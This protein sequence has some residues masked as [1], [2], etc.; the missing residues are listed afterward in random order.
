MCRS[1]IKEDGGLVG[2]HLLLDAENRSVNLVVDVGQVGDSR[3]LSNTAELVV[4]GS[5]TEAN[6][7]LVGSEIGNGD[8]SQMGADS[9]AAQDGGVTGIRDLSLG[10]LVECGGGGERVGLVDLGL[11]ET[12]HKD[13]FS[14][15]G[16]LENLTWGELGDVQLLVGVSDVPVTGEHLVVDDSENGLDSENV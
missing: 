13:H 2:E 7:S 15:P 14:V 3:S 12:T 10:L 8:A 4:D 11:G 6:P 1:Y 16:G 9:R 5:V